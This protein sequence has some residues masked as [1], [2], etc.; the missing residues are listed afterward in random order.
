MRQKLQMLLQTLIKDRHINSPAMVLAA[1]S[2]EDLPKLKPFAKH[3]VFKTFSPG[4]PINALP[5]SEG[6]VS[7][8]IRD[9]LRSPA[10]AGYSLLPPTVT[11]AELREAQCRSIVLVTDYSGS[12]DQLWN[13]AMTLVR[14]PTIRSWRSGGLLRIHAVT[15]AAT[16]AALGLA[17]E[18]KAPLDN[19]WAVS[20]VPTFDDRPWTPEMRRAIILLCQ[21]YTSS[22][23]KKEALGYRSSACLFA[24]EAGAPIIY[25][26]SCGRGKVAGYP[27]L[28]VGGFRRSWPVN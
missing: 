28:K 17:Y 12:G 7:N 11:L 3:I 22:K 27:S 20:S 18:P 6:F 13:H 8:L 21:R 24:T 15:Y 4:S 26:I 10:K 16:P 23:H 14:H 5:G 1:L 2:I 19:L 25:H 9:L